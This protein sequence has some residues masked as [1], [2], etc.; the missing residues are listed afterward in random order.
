MKPWRQMTEEDIRKIKKEKCKFC[1]YS[2]RNS[3]DATSEYNI[4]CAYIDKTGHSRGCRPDMC[5]KFER[6]R[7]KKK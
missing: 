3:A 4:T 2:S 5:D 1:K 7:R 6:R